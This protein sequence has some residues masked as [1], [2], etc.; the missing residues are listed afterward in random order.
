MRP[1]QLT[2]YVGC[3]RGLQIGTYLVDLEGLASESKLGTYNNTKEAF[4]TNLPYGCTYN[5]IH[6]KVK[7]FLLQEECFIF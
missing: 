5:M 4:L 7:A 2:G 3:V 6:P 1:P